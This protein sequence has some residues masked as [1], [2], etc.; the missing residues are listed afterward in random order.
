MYMVLFSLVTLDAPQLA[1]QIIVVVTQGQ[2]SATAL[3]SFVMTF[4]Q[5]TIGPWVTWRS[6][7]EEDRAAFK[8]VVVAR[9]AIN[10]WKRKFSQPKSNAVAPAP[11]GVHAAASAFAAGKKKMK[12]RSK[13]EQVGGMETQS[14]THPTPLDKE[15]TSVSLAQLFVVSGRNSTHGGSKVDLAIVEL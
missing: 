3:F 8:R 15:S 10:Q 9:A 7:P 6:L 12:K 2:A 11:D 4:L 5:I 13:D 1:M 14:N